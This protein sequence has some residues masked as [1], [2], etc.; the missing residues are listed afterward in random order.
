M[1]SIPS[2]EHILFSLSSLIPNIINPP[3]VLAKE[4]YVS[5][6]DFGNFFFYYLILFIYNISIAET[7]AIIIAPIPTIVKIV[8]NVFGRKSP[9]I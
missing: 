6:N 3:F 2:K 4:E 8:A 5:H 9:A 1:F 7:I